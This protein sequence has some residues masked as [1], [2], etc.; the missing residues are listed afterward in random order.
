MKNLVISWDI[1]E[2][3]L[4]SGDFVH[5]E[6]VCKRRPT[7]ACTGRRLYRVMEDARGLLGEYMSESACRFRP[8]ETENRASDPALEHKAECFKCQHTCDY[9]RYVRGQPTDDDERWV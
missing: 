9:R 2:H 4:S 6:G 8:S 3:G 7:Q 5:L 1:T